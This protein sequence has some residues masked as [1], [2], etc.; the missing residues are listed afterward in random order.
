[1]NIA[2]AITVC[3]FLFLPLF[4]LVFFSGHPQANFLAFLVLVVAGAS[5]ILDG[6]LARKTKQVT[7]IGQ[8]LDPL[9]DKLLMITVMLCFVISGRL[10]W[11]EA[12][13]F[14]LRDI[15]MIIVSTF[16]YFRGKREVPPAN[17]FGKA[18][19]VMFY[20]VFLM[21]MFQLPFYREA[22]WLVIGFSFITSLIYIYV[23]LRS[24][25]TEQPKPMKRAPQER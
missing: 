22:L 3:R 20:I 10:Y 23:Y 13:I 21:V 9:A 4:Y 8:L 19:T 1:M 15:S 2:N 11:I 7:V 24:D 18:T 17:F 12:G 5:D 25:Q 6:Y 16:L 14:F